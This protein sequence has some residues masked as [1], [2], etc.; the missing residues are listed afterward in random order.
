MLAGFTTE[1]LILIVVMVS[2]VSFI[3]QMAVRRLFPTRSIEGAQL[4]EHIQR[5]RV[6]V[7]TLEQNHLAL[8][9]DYRQLERAVRGRMMP[10]GY[11]EYW[12]Q[13]DAQLKSLQKAVEDL[14]GYPAYGPKDVR[15]SQWDRIA[16]DEPSDEPPPGVG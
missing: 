15:P 13:F 9:D 11:S 6:R 1:G 10:V 8:R 7:E 2:G 4:E 5:L 12:S 14:A 16:N 3:V